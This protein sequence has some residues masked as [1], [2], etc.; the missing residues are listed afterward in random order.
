[1]KAFSKKAFTILYGKILNWLSDKLVNHLR[2]VS[3]WP[4]LSGTKYRLLEKLAAGGMG[5]IYL[6]EDRQLQRRVALKVLHLPEAASDLSTRMWREA[7]VIAKLEHPSIVPVHDVGELPDGR[8]FYVMKFVQGQRLDQYASAENEL[9]N[10]LRIFQKICEA[11][12]FAHANGVIHRDLKPENI[13]VGAFGEV[14]VMDWGLAKIVSG[15]LR[16]D[17][18]GSKIDDGSMMNGRSLLATA[19]ETQHGAVMGTPAYMAPEQK[20]GAI[21]QI[22]Q[23]TDV[24]AL[25]AILKFLLGRSEVGLAPQESRSVTAISG[26]SPTSFKTPKALSA[27]YNQAMRENKNERYATALEL[28]NDIERF[29]NDL[30][31]SSY[32]ENFFEILRR[33]L[34]KYQFMV[35]LVFIYL[36]VRLLLFFWFRP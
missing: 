24:Y 20:R 22:D 26:A 7:R 4:D 27:I 2:A 36:L 19:R 10:R 8:V 14:L 15:E 6:A 9:P 13:M 25:G 17:D 31:V 21:E 23:R 30:S 29:L 32:R 16:S 5:T 1:M 28:A 33:W 3:D 34:K 12:A 18:G 11:V 35:L